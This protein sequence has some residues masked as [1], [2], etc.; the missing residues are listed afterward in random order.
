M[1]KEYHSHFE[2]YRGL[3]EEISKLTESLSNAHKNHMK[4]K[5][6]CDLCCIDFSI[7]PVEFYYIL[8]HLKNERLD[9]ADHLREDV[10]VFLK[11]HSCTI[12]QFRPIMCRTQGFPLVY[13]NDDGEAELSAC[14]L[15][16]TDFDYNDFTLENT[17]PQ[18]KYNS[19]LFMLN[20]EFIADFKEKKYHEMDLIP[21]KEIAEHLKNEPYKS[22]L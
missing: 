3:I 20:K 5:N 8:N 18:D 12:Y 1:S 19:K 22:N 2:K 6:G 10:C 13:V 16:F 14:H 21:L 9:S 7:F 4:C 11:N 17:F 15:N